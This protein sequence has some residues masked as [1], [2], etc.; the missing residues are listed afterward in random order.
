MAFR[1]R[2]LSCG[3]LFSAPDEVLDT[4]ISC[5]RCKSKFLAQKEPGDLGRME[6]PLSEP[7][8][9]G[10]PAV[11]VEGTPAEGAPG[12]ERPGRPEF[13]CPA[14]NTGFTEEDVLDGIA[15]RRFNEDYVPEV[16]CLKHFRRQFPN[17][18]E[19]HPGTKAVA[20]CSRCDRPL[21]ENCVVE[22]QDQK[23]CSICKRSVLGELRGDYAPRPAGVAYDER[24]GLPW[25][26]PGTSFLG[27]MFGTVKEVLFNP[28]YAFRKMRVYGG[29]GK[30]LLYVWLLWTAGYF[31]SY[32]WQFMFFGAAALGVSGLPPEMA[33][34]LIAMLV[35]VFVLAAIITLVMPF[36]G[37]ALFHVCLMMF[38]GAKRDYECTYR[39]V[40]YSLGS[41]SIFYIIPVVGG[42][43]FMI[44]SIVAWII[45]L[46]KAHET[47]GG[48]AALAVLLPIMLCCGLIIAVAVLPLLMMRGMR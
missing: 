14:C 29:I 34:S 9:P 8:A 46:A 47:T 39:V 38:G 37:A 5:P 24:P 23:L 43:I 12:R 48:K 10:P 19:K 13:F 30:P 6:E 2:C 28:G 41:A 16:Y 1:T 20:R 18:C 22:L 26:Q 25:E 21:C 3:T 11:S 17:E 31:L 36:I 32:V 7:A 40:A 27:G 4:E 15:I 44:W 35:M 42:F 33:E 45:G